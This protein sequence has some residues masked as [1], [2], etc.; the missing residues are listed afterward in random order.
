MQ[1]FQNNFQVA[2]LSNH[3][4]SCEVD[5]L[6]SQQNDNLNLRKNKILSPIFHCSVFNIDGS[7]LGGGT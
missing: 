7:Q 4:L 5:W 1:I 6:N 3:I 2:N